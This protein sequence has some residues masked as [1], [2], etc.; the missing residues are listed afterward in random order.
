MKRNDTLTPA[1][2]GKRAAED[3]NDL[4]R[5]IN[6]GELEFDQIPTLKSQFLPL[7]DRYSFFLLMNSDVPAF[8]NSRI[9]GEFRGLK[10]DRIG[11]SRHILRIEIPTEGKY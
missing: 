10:V 4:L 5:I 8:G 9:R 2:R 11:A 3:L 6:E 7:Y 1:N